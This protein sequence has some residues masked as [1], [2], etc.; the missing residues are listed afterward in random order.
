MDKHVESESLQ[1]YYDLNVIRGESSS[2]LQ[3]L[4]AQAYRLGYSGIA[5]SHVTSGALSE[6]DRCCMPTY[7]PPPA[8]HPKISLCQ[9]QYLA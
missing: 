1:M 5:V 3:D 4:K 8:P 6:R 2:N 9:H 7:T